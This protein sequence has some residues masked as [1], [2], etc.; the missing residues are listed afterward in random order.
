MYF[1]GDGTTKCEK[2]DTPCTQYPSR[3]VSFKLEP[4]KPQ[5]MVPEIAY[6]WCQLT[7]SL[8]WIYKLTFNMLNCFKDYK[9]YILI[10]NCILDLAWHKEMKL[11]LEQYMLSVLH[12]LYHA[13]WR[14]VNF[15]S[16]DIIRH[17]LTPKAGIFRL[18]H[19]KS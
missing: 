10:L 4:P 6:L 13:C 12:S 5:V 3:R 11:T 14:S 16:Q 18:Q 9:R 17:R 1:P 2:L 19:Q 7:Y 8:N 15:R